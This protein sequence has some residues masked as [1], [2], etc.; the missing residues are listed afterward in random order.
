M[1]KDLNLFE[2]RTNRH[3]NCSRWRNDQLPKISDLGRS[4]V[5]D[6][7]IYREEEPSNRDLRKVARENSQESK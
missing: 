7:I 6:E 5:I 1:R 2:K 3:L 4:C